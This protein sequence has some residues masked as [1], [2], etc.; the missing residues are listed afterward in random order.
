MEDE[1]FDLPPGED[2]DGSAT[3]SPK[4]YLEEEQGLSAQDSAHLDDLLSETVGGG[5][6]GKR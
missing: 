6:L 3:T 4:M 2:L 5:L 1:I